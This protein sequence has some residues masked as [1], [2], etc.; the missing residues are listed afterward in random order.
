MSEAQPVIQKKV[1]MLGAYA[2][3]KTSLVSRFVRSIFSDKYLTTVGVKVDKKTVKI[4]DRRLSLML[5][6]LAGEDDLYQVRMTY[7]RGSAGVLLVADGTRR[8]TLDKA[9]DLQ[10]RAEAEIGKVPIILLVNKLDAI[11][12]WE[13]KTAELQSLSADGWQVVATSAKTGAGV[14][15]SFLALGEKML[16]G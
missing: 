14:N 2:V 6:D 7:L 9:F 3:G 13:I 5:W 15:G 16:A 4:D 8:A 1:C 10:Q 11:E 12:E